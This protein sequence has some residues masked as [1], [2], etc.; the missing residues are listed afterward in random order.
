MALCV[1]RKVGQN[2]YDLFQQTVGMQNIRSI[3]HVMDGFGQQ[4]HQCWVLEYDRT[5]DTKI[6]ATNSRQLKWTDQGFQVGPNCKG[7]VFPIGDHQC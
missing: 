4:S 1:V 7:G 5:R 2:R 6:F 3:L